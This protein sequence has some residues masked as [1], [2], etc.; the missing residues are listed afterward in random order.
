[1]ANVLFAQRAYDLC[2]TAAL[3]RT[4]QTL[5]DLFTVS[6]DKSR[7]A[8]LGEISRAYGLLLHVSGLKNDKATCRDICCK[9]S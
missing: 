7:K 3:T 8:V 2:K 5:D 4:R 1:M 6:E 9:V